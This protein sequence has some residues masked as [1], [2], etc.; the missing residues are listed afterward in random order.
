MPLYWENKSSKYI[1]ILFFLN[2][3]QLR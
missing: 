1:L 2:S 3:I